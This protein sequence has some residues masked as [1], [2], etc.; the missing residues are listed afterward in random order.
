MVDP[1]IVFDYWG[2]L[3]LSCWIVL[4]FSAETVEQAKEKP[5]IFLMA[6]RPDFYEQRGDIPIGWQ[7]VSINDAAVG[8]A[9]LE[10]MKSMLNDAAHEAAKSTTDN[11]IIMTMVDNPKL[12]EDYGADQDLKRLKLAGTKRVIRYTRN[13]KNGKIDGISEEEKQH[14]ERTPGSLQDDMM[15]EQHELAVLHAELEN[16]QTYVDAKVKESERK[17]KILAQATRNHP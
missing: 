9:T 15:Q 2:V 11:E 4:M 6:I 13:L 14:Y 10:A 5:G 3:L 12:L 17:R 1:Y 8:N 7:I 16:M